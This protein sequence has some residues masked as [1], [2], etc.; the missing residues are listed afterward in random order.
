MGKSQSSAPSV[1]VRGAERSIPIHCVATYFPSGTKGSMGG[2][3]SS[4]FLPKTP[5]AVAQLHPA[6][7]SGLSLMAQ[8][9]P[10]SLTLLAVLFV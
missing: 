1:L 4:H 6:A 10:T 9:G 5:A 8:S 3:V 7:S 2:V